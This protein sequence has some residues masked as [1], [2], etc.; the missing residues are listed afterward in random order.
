[1]R[2]HQ[3]NYLKAANTNKYET[4]LINAKET[5]KFQEY[6]STLAANKLAQKRKAEDEKEYRR[7]R[8]KY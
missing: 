4:V 2:E 3:I 1:M 5:A 6:Q 8:A 7:G